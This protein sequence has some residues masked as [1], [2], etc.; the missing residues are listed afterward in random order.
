MKEESCDINEAG[1][2]NDIVNRIGKEYAIDKAPN[3]DESHVFS[4]VDISNVDIRAGS[5][6][7]VVINLVTHQLLFG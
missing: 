1:R 3:T 2:L 6:F 5:P 7:T 4:R